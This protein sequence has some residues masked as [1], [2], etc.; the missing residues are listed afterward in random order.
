MNKTS[1]K[2]VERWCWLLKGGLP[3]FQE[4]VAKT[5]GPWA[6]VDRMKKEEKSSG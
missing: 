2:L 3:K 5:D 4:V 1:E 6:S